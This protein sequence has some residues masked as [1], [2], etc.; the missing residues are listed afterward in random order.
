MWARR[1]VK[2]GEK[3]V[4]IEGQSQRVVVAGVVKAALAHVTWNDR[5]WWSG[6]GCIFHRR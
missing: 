3:M 1:E 6:C 5:R 2:S 4:G